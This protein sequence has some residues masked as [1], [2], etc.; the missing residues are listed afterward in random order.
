L[1]ISLWLLSLGSS[2]LS[3]VLAFESYH[4]FKYS[5]KEYLLNFSAGFLLLALSYLILVLIATGLANIPIHFGDTDDIAN[6]PVIA[7]METLGY[8]LIALAYSQTVRTKKTLTF[9]MTMVVFLVVLA[10]VSKSFVPANV[11]IAVYLLNTGLLGFVLYHMLKVMPPVDLV[12]AGFLALAMNEYTMLIGA[13]NES[14]F[15]YT[16]EGTFLFAQILRFIALLML[17]GAF[18]VSRRQVVRPRLVEGIEG[19]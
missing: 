14:L 11:D 16:D 6:F 10:L 9:L 17:V 7:V 1:E 5:K 2:A 18:L 4:A 13:V 19:A 8:G 12:F 3:F 15:T